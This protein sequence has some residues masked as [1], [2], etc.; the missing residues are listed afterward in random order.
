MIRADVGDD[1]KLEP[2]FV[3]AFLCG[4]NGALSISFLLFLACINRSYLSHFVSTETEADL[5]ERLFYYHTEPELK[6]KGTFHTPEVNLFKIRD[7]L[8]EYIQ[9]NI[10]TWERERHIWWT[11]AF[12]AKNPDEML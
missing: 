10:V 4:A 9:A 3:W 1:G 5:A 2:G 8:K 11:A 12:L 7:E 6:I